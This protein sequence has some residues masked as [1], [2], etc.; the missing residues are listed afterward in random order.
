[1]IIFNKSFI[2]GV[3]L[4]LAAVMLQACSSSGKLQEESARQ[5]STTSFQPVNG[6]DVE[7][8]ISAGDEIE[9]LVWEQPS[10]NTLTRVSNVGTIAVPLIGEKH[11]I[12]LTQ[13]ELRRDLIRD[14]SRYIAGEIS[15]TVSVRNIQNMQVAVYGMVIRPDN[16]PI[17][18]E[19]SVFRVLSYAGGPSEQANI[20]S[21][22][23][24]RPG[25][26]ASSSTIDLTQYLDS[27]QL[28]SA[29]IR[30]NPG[31]IVYVP[32]KENAIREMSD[33]LRDAVLLFGIFR[34]F[35]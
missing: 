34:V 19:T 35:N 8:R 32:R 17:T 4:L 33:F 28:E 30:V 24:Y 9:I 15:L 31:D 1:M 26:D 22:K 23:I 10:F 11:V 16:Y 18:G 29:S 7:Y 5:L 3:S 2:Y 14:L 12:G 27:G 20:R 13:E 21:V 6:S 25:V